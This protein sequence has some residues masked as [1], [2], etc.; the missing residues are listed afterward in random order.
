MKHRRY[1]AK[2]EEYFAPE[3]GDCLETLKDSMVGSSELEL[4]IAEIRR[5]S[6]TNRID[7]LDIGIGD[8]RFAKKI[9]D[10]LIAE[11]FEIDLTGIEP[12]KNSFE[13]AKKRFPNAI[14]HND[15]IEN[16]RLDNKFD[17]VSFFQSLHYIND[18]RPVLGEITNRLTEGGV[19]ITTLWSRKDSLYQLSKR[20]FPN[21]GRIV[22]E[23]YF[24]LIEDFKD[25]EDVSI[26]YFKGGI[27]F[28][29]LL[30][31]E[32]NII[33]M[34]MVIS[35][36]SLETRK[37]G[38]SMENLITE[39]RRNFEGIGERI[40][41]VVIS[42]KSYEIIGLKEKNDRLLKRKFPSFGERIHE[43]QG[44]E[45]AKF[46]CA[47][48][49]ETRYLCREFDKKNNILEICCGIGGMSIVLGK[50]FETHAIDINPDRIR[51]AESNAETFGISNV[52]FYCRDVL[53]ENTYS[54]IRDIDLILVDVDWRSS[55]DD[56]IKKQPLSPMKTTPNTEALLNLLKSSY[57]QVPIIFKVS[58]FARVDDLQSIGF[59]KI[60]S[61]FI[62]GVFSAYNVY[63]D[64]KYTKNSKDKVFIRSEYHRIPEEDAVS[65]ESLP[66]TG[67]ITNDEWYHY[68]DLYNK[69]SSAVDPNFDSMEIISRYLEEI[70]HPVG[71][72]VDL[73][74]GTG[75]LTRRLRDM[76]YSGKL[77]AVENCDEM[78]S[79]L[80]KSDLSRNVVLLPEDMESFR[81]KNKSTLMIGHFGLSSRNHPIERL[82]NIYDN[83]S[84]NGLLITIGWD[85]E[86]SD[87]VSD[88]WYRFL[89]GK[90][91]TFDEWRAEIKERL[92]SPR[93][94]GLSWFD[95]IKTRV[96]F[97]DLNDALYTMGNLFGRA[98]AEE[99][100]LRKKKSW[101]LNIGITVNSRN[102]L[103][104]IIGG[105]F[106]MRD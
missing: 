99:I 57:P 101:G 87:E 27:D 91:K 105:D 13:A 94:M 59:C 84:D 26:K 53:D 48:E 58:P 40:N 106:R 33:S 74:A 44:D 18:K 3:Y 66:R 93:G 11:G 102:D 81:I 20:L 79:Y 80:R 61:M 90:K 75:K 5:K 56:P 47:W 39:I 77:F 76:D 95:K 31:S 86:F 4:I 88:A 98:M 64:P 19:L 35:R 42:R 50:A 36:Y 67:L 25:Y 9:V 89:S 6:P 37:I 55:L 30:E 34:L 8:G 7:W 17:V 2:Q 15:K 21:N 24:N 23:E 100:I 92:R 41:G 63:F 49:S 83:L 60:D 46:M 29:K 96:E 62:D 68:P 103:E 54:D 51:C 22:A 10:R 72:P 85:E 71:N 1:N 104:R 43:L 70:N 82:R 12:I 32:D 65:M 16:V 78:I 52:K 45:E 14:I 97:K 28:N 38:F 73:G 69:F